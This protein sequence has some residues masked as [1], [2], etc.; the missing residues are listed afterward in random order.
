LWKKLK[1]KDCKFSVKANNYE[2]TLFAFDIAAFSKDSSAVVIDVTKFYGSDVRG[3]SGLTSQLRD[4]YKVRN[5]DDSRS[6][7]H[8][9]K[10]FPLNIEVVQDFIQFT[11]QSIDDFITRR[12]HAT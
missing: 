11:S 8:S 3:I 9:V 4:S 5:L 1:M 6:F 7:I 10:S 2:P 12:T